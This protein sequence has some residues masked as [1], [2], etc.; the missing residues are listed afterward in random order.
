[1]L[2]AVTEEG[3]IALMLGPDDIHDLKCA[4]QR[5]EHHLVDDKKPPVLKDEVKIKGLRVLY[6]TPTEPG[7]VLEFEVIG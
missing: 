1:M 5:G 2:Y 3:K 6:S 4:I 7:R